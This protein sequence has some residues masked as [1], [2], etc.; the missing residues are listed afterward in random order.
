VHQINS[1]AI[2]T[3]EITEKIVRAQCEPQCIGTTFGN[4]KWKVPD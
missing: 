2:M 3:K 1:G 4:A